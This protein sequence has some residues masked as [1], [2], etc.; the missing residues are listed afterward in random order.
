[1]ALIKC[2][3]CGKE[4]SEKAKRCPHCGTERV[5]PIEEPL[6]KKCPECGTD[7]DIDATEC[8]NCGCPIE[9][10]NTVPEIPEPQ[11]VEISKISVNRNTKKIIIIVL[12]A[13]LAIAV[14]IGIILISKSAKE[15]KETAAAK[16]AYAD[17]LS[18]YKANLVLVRTVML[19]G[20]AEAETAGGLIHDVWYN[21]IYEKSDYTTNKYTRPSGYYV[22]FNTALGNLFKDSSFKSKTDSIKLNQSTVDSLMKKLVNPPDEYKEAYSAVRDLYGVYSDLC[23]CATNPTGNLQGYTSAFNTADSDFMKYYNALGLYID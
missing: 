21:A 6:T 3:V 12:A 7:I 9:E 5:F 20:A 17:N 16:Q 22:D 14:I 2:E 8:P 13:I 15:K 18:D 1:M 10:E 11:K 19:T 4:I 23:N